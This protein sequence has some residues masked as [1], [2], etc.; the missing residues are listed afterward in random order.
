MT[1]LTT[2]STRTP[3]AAVSFGTTH[4]GPCG[5]TREAGH[6]VEMERNLA[7][8]LT[9]VIRDEAD[10]WDAVRS[11]TFPHPDGEYTEEQAAIITAEVETFDLSAGARRLARLFN[12]YAAHDGANT[13]TVAQ[14]RSTIL[15]ELPKLNDVD[16]NTGRPYIG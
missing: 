12:T 5:R 10:T 6:L 1:T 2:G 15:R 7:T 11:C 8:M 9:L 4:C 14:L 3:S 13:D 16:P